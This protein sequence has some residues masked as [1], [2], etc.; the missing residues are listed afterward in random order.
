[1]RSLLAL[2]VVTATACSSEEGSN[3]AKPATLP[4]VEVGVV[5]L[6]SQSVT[7]SRQLAGRT[8]AFQTS[9]VRPQVAGIIESREFKEGS[10]VKR[11]QPLYKID[12]ARYRAARDEARAALES[13]RASAAAL[14]SKARRYRSLLG[15]E[16]VGEQEVEDVIASAR[17][18]K[19]AVARAQA[20][21][22]TASLDLDYTTIRAPI[23]GRIGRSLV[24]PGALV[25]A[26]QAQPLSTIQQLDPIFVDISQSS[27][28]LLELRRQLA[29]GSALPASATLTLTL[30]DGTAYEHEG[31]LEFAE[32]T[33]DENTGSVTLRARFPNPDKTLLPGM[34]VR[35]NAPQAV[36]PKALL[37]P[38]Q[39]IARDPRG[40]ATAMVVGPGD[41]AERREVVTGQAVGDSWLILE[42]LA[43]GDKLIVEGT[44][45]IRPGAPLKPAPANLGK[46]KSP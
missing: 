34:F 9:E 17:Q 28:E 8:T 7:L 15:T 45:K 38:Q 44:S 24:T 33:V 43:A 35:V 6:E 30:E 12:A 37:A 5:T 31:S 13:A 2:S 18:A 36:V 10:E 39:G 19:A 1:M 46:E 27:A 21:L 20:S 42:G 26:N 23:A 4:P 16:A 41:V 11:G 3:A 29:G 22:K 32:A 40:G 14:E 25:T